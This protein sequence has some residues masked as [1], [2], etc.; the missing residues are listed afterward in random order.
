MMSNEQRAAYLAALRVEL[1]GNE[2]AGNADGVKDVSAEIRR[3][4]GAATPRE[5][6]QRR[7]RSAPRRQTR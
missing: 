4:E 7:P 5:K 3:V 6:A 1:E 2:R